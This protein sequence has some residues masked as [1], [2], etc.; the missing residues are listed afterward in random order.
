MKVLKDQNK[1]MVDTELNKQTN[2]DNNHVREKIKILIKKKNYNLRDLSRNIKKNDAYL[3]QYLYRGTPK[4][5]PEKYRLMLADILDVNV[6]EL[7]P[8]W[9][10]NLSSQ[11]N[12]FVFKNIENKVNNSNKISLSRE[13]LPDLDFFNEENLYYF[14]TLTPNGYITTI[15]DVSIKKFSKSDIYLLND[16]KNY[17][18]ANI[19]L[20]KFS[21]DKLSVKPYF[22]HFS[23]F[24]INLNKLD[25]SGKILWQCSKILTK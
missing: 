11:E 9:L 16:K 20:S 6:N 18:L 2:S 10:K 23:P 12:Y 19:E 17:F 8:N 24:Q 15:V 7:M 22:N 4:V 21:R 13:L 25:I 5:L 14:Q 3:Q 1:N